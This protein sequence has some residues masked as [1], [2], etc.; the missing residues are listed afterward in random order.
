MFEMISCH[1][2]IKLLVSLCSFCFGDKAWKYICQG[3]G[4]LFSLSP[5]RPLPPCISPSLPPTPYLPPTLHIFLPPPALHFYVHFS[6][7]LSALHIYP[8]ISLPPYLPRS[9]LLFLSLFHRSNPYYKYRFRRRSPKY[10]IIII[11][12]YN[13]LANCI[14]WNSFH[15]FCGKHDNHLFM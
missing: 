9:T 5:C 3:P 1:K 13:Y 12:T 15:A 7:P 6:L 4:E 10:I 2:S 11:I 8:H 14:S